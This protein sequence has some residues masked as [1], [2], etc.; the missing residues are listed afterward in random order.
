M[1]YLLQVLNIYSFKYKDIK[2]GKGLFQG[3]M[4]D[5]I[6]SFAV[7]KDNSGFDKVDYSKID[8]KF[9]KI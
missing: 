1:E 5:E 7:I 4:S 3:V 2:F 6:P 8:V 9:K